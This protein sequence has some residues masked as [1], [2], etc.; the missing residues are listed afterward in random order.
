MRKLIVL[1]AVML[2][3]GAGCKPPHPSIVKSD[4]SFDP[5]VVSGVLIAPAISTIAEMEDPRLLA[6]PTTNRM[7]AEQLGERTDYKFISAEQFKGAVMRGK[8][9]D[10]Y[11]AFRDLWGDKREL[12]AEF[13]RLLQKELNVETVLIPHVYLW[14]KDEAD[15]RERATASATQVGITLTLV[16]MATGKILWEGTDENYKE[17]VRSEDREVITTGGMDRRVEGVSATGDDQ[18]AAP[19]YDDVVILV[20]QSLVGALPERTATR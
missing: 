12:D 3:L 9:Q 7:L 10:R 4:P 8:L 15:Y 1:L 18:Y 14:H 19:P 2:V 11:T 5:N 17:S 6:E 16:E 13:L 20:L